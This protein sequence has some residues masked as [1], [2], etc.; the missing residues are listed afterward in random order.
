MIKNILITGASKGI[1]R[2]ISLNL[3]RRKNINLIL[4]A[5][6]ESALN[7]TLTKVKKFSPNS[8]KYVCD[9]SNFERTK[10]IFQKI[11]DRHFVIDVLINN[12][13]IQSPIGPFSSTDF[14]EWSNN[15]QVN[16]LG[17]AHLIK[18]VLPGMI[19][20]GSG[21]IINFS[22][23]GAT[24]PRPNFSAYAVSKTAVVRLT[25]TLSEEFK[26]EN[27]NIDINAVAPGA[28]NT[29][30][31]E[32][33]ISAG[34]KAGSEY[35]EAVKR[36]KEGGTDISHILKLIDFLISEESNGISGKLISAPWD[37]W[38]DKKF[39]KELKE[40]SNLATLRRIDNKYFGEL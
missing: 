24:S 10:K 9:I 5:R 32:E 19:K 16:L 2:E 34:E 11:I 15:I 4:L 40:S 31:L 38:E 6:N 36:S 12:A 35:M 37:K 23:G 21:K 20:K 28:I 22:G 25:E 13:A 39:L 30:M 17:S 1:G 18:L 29:S 27:L 26:K 8:Q 7:D 3:A 33:V 14:I